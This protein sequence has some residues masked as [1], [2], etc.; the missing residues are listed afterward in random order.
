MHSDISELVLTGFVEPL[1]IRQIQ[2]GALC[3]VIIYQEAPRVYLS[4]A[5]CTPSSFVL[6]FSKLLQCQITTVFFA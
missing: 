6:L 4:S 1:Y 5:E 2:S 3:R